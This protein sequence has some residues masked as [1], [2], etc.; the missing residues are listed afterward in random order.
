MIKNRG[1]RQLIDYMED[2]FGN[3]CDDRQSIADIFG[4]FYRDLY[5]PKVH[6]DAYVIG[7]CEGIPLFTRE[8]IRCALKS[9]KSGKCADS[10]GV[11]A[12]MLK[13]GGDQ[14]VTV[15]LHVFNKIVTGTFE[16]PDMWAKSVITVLFKSGAPH[17]PENHRPV[18]ILL[19]LYKL[20][21]R[22]LYL[23]LAPLLDREQS[24]A[25]AGFRI[26]FSTIDHL[27]TISHIIEKAEE[28]NINLWVAAVDYRKAFD[29]IEHQSIWRALKKQG[30][31]VGYIKLLSKLYDGQ[32]VNSALAGSADHFQS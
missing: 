26:G 5:A 6:Y 18:T 28:W 31:P 19:L 15:L 30:V 10:N 7:C 8:E 11:L 22:L 12:E 20:F 32:S 25:Q 13:A 2:R 16:P 4:A 9:L 29:S 1:K 27:W 23:R 14:L 21:A 3:R 24:S 17:L